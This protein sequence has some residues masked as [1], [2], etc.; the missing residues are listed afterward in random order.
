MIHLHNLC[1]NSALGALHVSGRAC[2][3]TVR[4]QSQTYENA[5]ERSRRISKTAHV[6]LTL[7]CA[8]HTIKT[9]YTQSN[10]TSLCLASS[11]Y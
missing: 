2:D 6:L 3:T 8:L 9:I 5:M 10:I 4:S 7:N 1:A 11:S